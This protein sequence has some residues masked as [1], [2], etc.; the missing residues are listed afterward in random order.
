[1]LRHFTFPKK[2]KKIPAFIDIKANETLVNNQMKHFENLTE[3]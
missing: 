1:M 3:P 2:K